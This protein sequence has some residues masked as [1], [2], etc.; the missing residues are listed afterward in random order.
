MIYLTNRYWQISL[1]P[2]AREKTAFTTHS[3]LYRFVKMPF[4]LHGATASFQRDM[5]KVPKGVWDSAV[6]YID[7]IE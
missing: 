6:I 5:D 4:C 2:T 7:D 1:A 3:G